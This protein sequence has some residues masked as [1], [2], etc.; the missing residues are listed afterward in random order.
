VVFFF[1][2]F[3]FFLGLD[4]A[5]DSVGTHASSVVWGAGF[6]APGGLGSEPPEGAGGASG[7]KGPGVTAGIWKLKAN[8]SD[9]SS[10]QTVS[11]LSSTEG[12]VVS[13]KDVV[14]TW[15]SATTK[16]NLKVL[17]VRVQLSARTSGF[18]S[19][20]LDGFDFA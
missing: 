15:S 12:G 7:A 9:P 1:P 8:L 5:I 17:S 18:R 20:P 13:S 11:L 6:C 16:L 4:C 2:D 3:F 14:A 19:P 10:L